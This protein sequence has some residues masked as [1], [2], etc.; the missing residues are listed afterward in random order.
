MMA[1]AEDNR[2]GG[3]RYDDAAPLHGKP[4]VMMGM[5]LA[6]GPKPDATRRNDA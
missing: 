5:N 4:P 2:G 1:G 6:P 3:C